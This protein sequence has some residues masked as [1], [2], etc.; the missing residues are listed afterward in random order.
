[1]S[2]WRKRKRL[3][4]TIAGGA[5][6]STASGALAPL[7][8][9]RSRCGLP[10]SS[11]AE[12]GSKIMIGILSKVS[13]ASSYSVIDWGVRDQWVGSTEGTRQYISRVVQQPGDWE[14]LP[15]LDPRKGMLATQIEALRLVGEGLDEDTPFIATIFSPLAQARHLAGGR[16]DVEPYAQ[17][18]RRFPR[19]IEDDNKKHPGLH[20]G[21]QGNGHKRYLLCHPRHCRYPLMNPNEFHN[22]GR[23]YD[24]RILRE[25]D[26]LWLNM[27]HIHGEKIMFK[28]AADYPVQ[29]VNW[30]DRDNDTLFSGRLE[31]G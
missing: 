3:E 5:S 16:T 8:R 24:L 4:T 7:A 20:R 23:T 12:N 2:Y 30:H 1:M 14:T 19:R 27:L 25:L 9:R 22:F 13:P 21:G 28:E 29:F 10:G 31:A 18:S 17:P 6:R 11:T 26:G 15:L